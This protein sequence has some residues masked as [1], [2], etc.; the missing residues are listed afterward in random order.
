M[1]VFQTMHAPDHYE[2]SVAAFNYNIMC[3]FDI[4]NNKNYDLVLLIFVCVL[5]SKQ[6]QQ[7][8][9]QASLCHYFLSNTHMDACT[10]THTYTCTHTY[11]PNNVSET[12]SMEIFQSRGVKGFFS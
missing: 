8:S 5:F 2:P 7:C 10:H 11:T 9:K 3:C 12:I 6:L 4:L 1:P